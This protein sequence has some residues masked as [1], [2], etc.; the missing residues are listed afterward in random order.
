MCKAEKLIVKQHIIKLK[1]IA[2]NQ[3]PF[4]KSMHPMYNQPNI[5]G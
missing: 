1:S 5:K 4:A 2:K 3:N